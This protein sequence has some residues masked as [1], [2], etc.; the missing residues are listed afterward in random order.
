MSRTR[1]SLINFFFAVLGQ[2]LGLIISF[3]ARIFFIKILGS[4]YLGLNGLFTN[5]LTVLSLAELGVGTAITYSLYAPLANK[6]EKKCQMLMQLYRKIYIVIGL[7]I[8]I[9]GIAITPFLSVFIKDLPNIP[10]INLIYILFV[11]NTAISYFYSYKRNL[12]IADQS[13]YIATIYRYGYYILLNIFQII[14]LVITKDYIGF[15]ILQIIFTFLENVSVSLKADKMY[16]FLKDK[17]K[18]KLDDG[19]KKEIIKNTK[20]MMMHKVGDVIVNSTDNILLSSFVSLT[21]VGLYSNYYLITNALNIVISQVYNSITAS[22]GNL[23]A[24]DSPKKQYNVFKKINFLTFWIYCFTTTCLVILVNPFIEIWI[25]KEYLFSMSIVLVIIINFYLSGMRKSVL[26]FREAAGLFYRDRYKPIFEAIVNLVISIILA[27]K[28]GTIGIFL[29][30]LISTVTVCFWIEP[31]IL[32]KYEFHIGVKKYFIDYIKKGLLMVGICLF[33]YILC[34]PSLGNIYIN[35]IYKLLICIIVPNMTLFLIYKNSNEFQ[36]FYK[37]LF[38]KVIKKI[39]EKKEKKSTKKE[40]A[41]ALNQKG[42]IKIK[43]HFNKLNILSIIDLVLLIILLVLIFNVNILPTKYLI[44]VIVL[45]L[46]INILGIVLV[47]LKKK[48]LK[49]I[50]VIILVLSILLSG[51]GSYYLFYTNNFLNESFNSVKKKVSTYYIVTSSNNKYSKKS[52]IK[53]KVY[54]YKN[55]A[56]IKNVLKVVKEDLNVKTSSYDDVTS[57]IQD[58]VN[59]KIDFMLIDKSSYNIVLDL[60][61]NISKKEL[62]VVYEFDIEKYENKK[63]DSKDAFNI[64]ISGKD[65]AGLT[66]YNAIVTVNTNTHEILLTSIPRDYYMEIAGQNGKK[67]SLSHLFI[68]DEETLEKTL[69][70]FFD[71]DIDYVI[72]IK[73]EGLVKIVD[74]VGGITYC[75]DQAFTTTHALILNDYNDTG[76]QKLYVKKGCQELNGIETLTVARER[77]AFVGRDRMRQKNAQ[78]IIIAIFDKMKSANLFANYNNILNALGDSYSTNIPKKVI[79]NIA[80]DTIDGAEWNIM[81]QS[82]DGSDKWDAD[83]AILNDKGYAMIPNTQDIVNATNKMNE[84]LNNN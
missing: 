56:N 48:V 24:T 28:F 34:L 57:M 84:V 66:D 40:S 1:S 50:G 17:T 10:N 55:N 51:V 76:K 54:Y 3:I 52:D 81:T 58:V 68:Y 53:G 37:N 32:Y 6:D 12:I 80:K 2:G 31:L 70:N 4:E 47:N 27:I 61:N 59:K 30:T 15:L 78:K 60:D 36:Y 7:F 74:E 62:K 77:N 16:P 33:V 9:V 83:I 46:V 72:N 19:S 20:A 63:E 38:L 67:D 79:T 71:I 26:A 65:F 43:K 35:F 14:Y 75:S 73:A 22:I 11:V 25:G 82:V 23:C 5:I 13:R 29:G 8:L 39:K 42:N 21:A 18:R 45:L 64:L 69:E 44:L 41:R 49:I